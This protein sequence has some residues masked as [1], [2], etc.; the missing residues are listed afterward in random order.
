[1]A[2]PRPTPQPNPQPKPRPREGGGGG[3]GGSSGSVTGRVPDRRDLPAI[4]GLGF[5]VANPYNNGRP[6]QGINI[7][8]G[9]N[10]PL[11]LPRGYV[12][13]EVGTNSAIGRYVRLKGPG[14]Y[15]WLGH[16]NRVFDARQAGDL[17]ART[18]SPES[19]GGVGSGS[20]LYFAQTSGRT[21]TGATNPEG[22]YNQIGGRLL[23]Y[24]GP[25]NNA[26]NAVSAS[27]G[28]G[29]GGGGGGRQ[30]RGAAAAAAGALA[31]A[32]FSFPF[33]ISKWTDEAVSL[34][35]SG[36]DAVAYAYSKI[37]K[38]A[39]FRAHYP[40]IF[41]PDGRLRVS[42]VEYDL[43]GQRYTSLAAESGF[44][45]N[46]EL[47]G[48]SISSGLTPEEFGTRA[49][50]IQQL[51]TNPQIRQALTQTH[52]KLNTLKEQ[53]R[54]ILG[55]SD[56]TVYTAYETAQLRAASQSAGVPITA[57]RAERLAGRTPGILPME[58]AETRF[59]RI[60]EEG[61]L[62]GPELAQEG[63]RQRHL[64]II[65]FGGPNRAKIAAK[66]ER[67]LQTR[68]A[69]RAETPLASS[70]SVSPEGRL[71]TGLVRPRPGL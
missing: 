20:H 24:Q 60:A 52:P 46:R 6:H 50:A 59:A 2:E 36:S 37:I 53:M 11:Y 25:T 5:G 31:M 55:K 32:G 23:G 54:F 27:S 58:E 69:Q 8:T 49:R 48:L 38:S 67:I 18:G 47:I 71:T 10:T 43:L 68:Q 17:L 39:E 65:E 45:M 9:A 16:L 42:P 40:G 56:E 70:T 61:R 35:L 1:M 33:D 12:V 30:T 63:I 64:E 66:V 29:G 15:I 51:R 3:G 62:A 44:R 7:M 22:L 13:D 21:L 28:G 19:A 34:G 41:R 26:V 4:G 57:G 14:G